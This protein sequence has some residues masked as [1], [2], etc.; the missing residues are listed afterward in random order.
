MIRQWHEL[1]AKNEL[2]A[3]YSVHEEMFYF[4]NKVVVPENQCI[5][6]Q[7]F[8]LFHAVPMAGHGGV[9]K[10]YKAATDTFY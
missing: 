2:G 6:N 5:R 1:F 10:T 3:E 8:N 4:Q 7:I 9:N